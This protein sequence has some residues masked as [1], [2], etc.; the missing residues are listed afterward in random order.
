MLA[1]GGSGAPAQGVMGVWGLQS[2]LLVPKMFL[3]DP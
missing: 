2:A 3:R 1:S